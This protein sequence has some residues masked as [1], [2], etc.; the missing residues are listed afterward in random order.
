[1]LSSKHAMKTHFTLALLI[2][3]LFTA[4]GLYHDHASESEP[5]ATPKYTDI[6]YH[7]FSDAARHMHAGESPYE[8]DTYRYTP[9]LALLMQ[10]NVLLTPSFGKCVFVLFDLLCGWLIVRINGLNGIRPADAANTGRK[11]FNGRIETVIFR[12]TFFFLIGINIT[13]CVCTILFVRA[14]SYV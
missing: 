14:H 2:R 1:M 3:L 5:T 9:L 10:P 7:V 4:F 13:F 8:R 12:R 11:H 6:D